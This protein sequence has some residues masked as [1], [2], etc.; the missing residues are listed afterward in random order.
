MISGSMIFESPRENN[1]NSLQFSTE[2][3][4]FVLGK[5]DIY[6]GN[7]CNLS[8]NNNNMHIYEKEIEFYYYYHDVIIL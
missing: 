6:G 3:W 8:E 4:E 7:D 2:K 1:T 5:K